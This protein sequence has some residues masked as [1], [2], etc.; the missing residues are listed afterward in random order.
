M[1]FK[2]KYIIIPIV[3]AVIT[4]IS[5]F[6]Y[7]YNRDT[8]TLTVA[9]KKWI[10]DNI[11]TVI[12][13]EYVSNYPVFSGED[14]VFQ[15]FISTVKTATNLE[16]NEIPYQ[17]EED[18]KGDT[19]SFRILKSDISLGKNDH[20]VD[21]DAYVVFS[22]ERVKIN[23]VSDFQN[24]SLG[25]FAQDTAEISY[26]LRSGSNLSYKAYDTAAAIFEALNN[27]EIKFAII[28]NIMYL[29]ETIGK[30]YFIV[31][32]L[33]EMNKKIVFTTPSKASK[34]DSI[35]L[36]LFNYWKNEQYVKKY[37]AE[38]FDYYILANN[39][40]DQEK[41]E[42]LSKTYVY[43]YVENFPYEVTVNKELLGISGE[44]L[45][46]V[47]RLTGIEFSY[48]KFKTAKDLAKAVKDKK[49][50]LFF[51]YYDIDSLGYDPI[52]SAFMEQYVVLAKMRHSHVVNSFE[53]LKDKD[54]SMLKETALFNYFKDNS[55]ANIKTFSTYE[56]MISKSKN[57]I[58]VIDREVYNAYRNSKFSNYDLLYTSSINKDYNFMIK[59]EEVKLFN[60]FNYVTNTNSYFRYRNTAINKLNASLFEKMSFEQLYIII[61]LAIF[62]PLIVIITTATLVHRKRTIKRIKKE[63]RRKYTDM[64]TSLKNRNYLNLNL[65]TWNKNRTYPQAVI[66]VDLNNIKYV[67][68]NYGHEE[69]DELIIKA[70]AMLVNTQLENSEIIRT[71]GNEFLV[72]L[73]GYSEHQ[74]EIYTKKMAKEFKNLPY[75]FGAA[76]GYSMIVDDIKTVDD[77]IN[78]ATLQM[79]IN[80][81][82]Y[83]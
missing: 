79:R 31:H 82:E 50:D 26:Y 78:E 12:D 29:N 3:I 69:G 1:K 63:E 6:Y 7:V 43:G 71:D 53:S 20:L 2:K 67:N 17:K 73:V 72:Y 27:G 51:Y 44:Y 80:K 83:K 49:V 45:S 10:Q 9:D 65:D 68:D 33:T 32:T 54:I 24:F 48:R 38:L 5:V 36:K 30:D 23:D 47:S 15:S 66:I 42:L 34:L 39:I 56:E 25:V 81:G 11:D 62:I 40:T 60:I 57:N 61:L 64:L 22:K 14:G 19:Y 4:F 77:A 28:P 55:K 59:N 52:E 21:E 37:N 8:Y 41:S 35:M 18:A 16:F 74:I 75:N 13:I 46:R 70:A 76:L 58:L